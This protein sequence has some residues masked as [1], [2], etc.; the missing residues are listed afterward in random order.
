M[1]DHSLL[2][3]S[4]IIIY[5][6]FR[7]VNLKNLFKKN[8]DLY[9]KI[10]Y[11]FKSSKASEH[12]KELLV[13]KYSKL[14]IVV[15]LKILLILVFIVLFMFT[16][17]LLSNSFLSLMLSTYGIVALSIFITLYHILKKK[18]NRYHGIQKERL[19]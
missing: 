7:F 3:I 14:L 13:F 11:L 8:L 18:I 16:L 5:E 19:F 6:F 10:F 1:I 15:S 12:K 17:N 4:S 2:V 9:K